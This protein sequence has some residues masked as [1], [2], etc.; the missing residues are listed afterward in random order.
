MTVRPPHSDF[1]LV[2]PSRPCCP[3]CDLACVY[4]SCL[5]HAR[6][7]ILRALCTCLAFATMLPAVRSCVRCVLVLPS[8]ACCPACDLACVVPHAGIL[9]PARASIGDRLETRTTGKF[10][11]QRTSR[12]PD[13]APRQARSHGQPC[14]RCAF[15]QGTFDYLQCPGLRQGY[16]LEPMRRHMLLFTMLFRM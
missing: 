12:E 9:C 3:L 16:R 2:S 14:D 8:P 13:D 10:T 7:A 6:C 15:S 5:R 11:P 1:I 4:L